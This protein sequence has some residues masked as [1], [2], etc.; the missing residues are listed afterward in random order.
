MKKKK[1]LHQ[2][3]PKFVLRAVIPRHFN[4]NNTELAN[5]R[6]FLNICESYFYTCRT[7]ESNL[8]AEKAKQLQSGRT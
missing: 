4:N 8:V 2:T 1:I 7:F 5:A 3:D 6:S